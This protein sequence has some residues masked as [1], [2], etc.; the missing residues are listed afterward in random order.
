MKR[1][2]F[3][4]AKDRVHHDKESNGCKISADAKESAMFHTYGNRNIDEFTL[5]QC[6][7]DTVDEVPEQYADND[8]KQDP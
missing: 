1:F 6:R 2:V 3:H 7:A 5:L 8:G 4:L